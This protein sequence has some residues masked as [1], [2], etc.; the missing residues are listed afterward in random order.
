MLSIIESNRTRSPTTQGSFDH[1]H[2]PMR[3][4]SVENALETLRKY[5]TV[6]VVDD[7]RSMYGNLWKEV[8]H[9]P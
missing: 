2:T 9:Y 8:R 4:P 6:F 5:N 3:R 7:S 1:L